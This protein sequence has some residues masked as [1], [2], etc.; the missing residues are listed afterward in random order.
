MVLV[1]FLIQLLVDMFKW[2]TGKESEAT[3][4]NQKLTPETTEAP[5]QGKVKAA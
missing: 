1:G 2:I 3:P 5:D 4:A